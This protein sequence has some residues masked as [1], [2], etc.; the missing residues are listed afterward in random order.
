MLTVL[1]PV[2]QEDEGGGQTRAEVTAGCKSV[3]KV[4]LNYVH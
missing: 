4:L 1:V 2:L 3:S